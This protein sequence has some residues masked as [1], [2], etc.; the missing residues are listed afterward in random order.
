MGPA[1]AHRTWADQELALGSPSWPWGMLGCI[2]ARPRLGS[3]SRRRGTIGRRSPHGAPRRGC[4]ARR[5]HRPRPRHRN[6]HRNGRPAALPSPTG[7]GVSVAQLRRIAVGEPAGACNRGADASLLRA[8]SALRPHGDAQTPSQQLPRRLRRHTTSTPS[9]LNRPRLAAMF[10]E[11]AHSLY[12]PP[13]VARHNME[14]LVFLSSGWLKTAC[15]VLALFWC[16]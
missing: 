10:S 7:L 3:K 15:V 9:T 12:W 2:H 16:V 1:K 5:R 13:Q 14:A 11:S 4:L 6:G 8:E